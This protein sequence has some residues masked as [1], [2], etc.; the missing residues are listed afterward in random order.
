[1]PQDDR[2][3]RVI[4]DY[5]TRIGATRETDAWLRLNA[6]M[7]RDLVGAQ[8]CSIWLIDRKANQLWTK[9]AH[10]VEEIRIPFGHG[11]VGASISS[12]ETIVVNDTSKDERFLRNVGQGGG[13]VTR[14][15][16]VIPLRASGGK[17]IGALQA[18]NKPGGFSQEDVDL[19]GLAAG[20]SASALESQWLREQ[21]EAARLVL[22]ELE[23]ARDVQQRL[24]P[25]DPPRIPGLDYAAYCRP[26]KSV[27]GDYYDFIPLPGDSLMFTLG[28][29]S[30]K[31][32]AAA[33]LMASI[34]A[35][36]R[37]QAVRRPESLAELMDGFNQAVYSFSTDD[38]YSTLFVGLYDGA[39]RRLAYVNAGQVAPM[40]RRAGGAIERLEEGGCPVGLIS[41][42]TYDQGEIT[43][44]PGDFILGF[45]D[46]ITEATSR[47]G[48][49]WDESP[50]EQLLRDHAH[51]PAQA[52]IERLIA[53]AD[54]FAAGAEQADDM[55]ALAL[56]V[57]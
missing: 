39:S 52:V 38:K 57:L 36:L 10:G 44:A 19:L 46:G 28:D 2:I 8:R 18:L 20:Y 48:S 55:T 54:T 14:S 24:F 37:S 42:A 1:M 3:S 21:A 53:E 50:V 26:A 51:L 4:F 5:A 56:R 43:L 34:Q 49:M 27:G 9:V 6:D 12:N 13:F 25:Q 7:A 41:V 31:G 30:G 33:V 32:I 22:K 35:S 29:V 15:L 45:S 16:L 11:L 23:I 47:D 40:L 17:V